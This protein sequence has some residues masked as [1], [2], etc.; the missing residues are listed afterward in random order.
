MVSISKLSK[1]NVKAQ[2]LSV[3]KVDS[4]KDWNNLS[5]KY[6]TQWRHQG[7]TRGRSARL[8]PQLEFG[9]PP[10]LSGQINFFQDL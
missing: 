6:I 9:P 5:K 7:G 1:A 3:F 8:G 4:I 10:K 2:R